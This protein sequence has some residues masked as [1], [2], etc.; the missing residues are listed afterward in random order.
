MTPALRKFS[1]FT[2][3]AHRFLVVQVAT[4]APR[5]PSSRADPISQF[6]FMFGSELPSRRR[7]LAMQE[8]LGVPRH[9]ISIAFPTGTVFAPRGDWGPGVKPSARRTG[10]ISEEGQGRPSG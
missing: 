2:M 10:L 1:R 6:G 7:D 3:K 4:H 5:H 8:M 9:K